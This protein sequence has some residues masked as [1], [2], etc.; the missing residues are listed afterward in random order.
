M[1]EGVVIEEGGE[2]EWVGDGDREGEKKKKTT[3]TNLCKTSRVL[4]SQL[5]KNCDE[6]NWT[7]KK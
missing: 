6:Y 2:G 7:P 5:S 4:L 3:Q 1:G